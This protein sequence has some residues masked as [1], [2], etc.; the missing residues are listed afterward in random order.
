[1]TTNNHPAHGPVSLDR[2][3]QISE[4]LSKASA[5]SD[6][7]NLGYAM[8][9]AVK[10]IDGAIA[11]FGAEPV[12][13]RY[14]YVHTPKTE[15]HGSPFT[16]EWKLCDSEDE[17]NPSDCFERQPLYTAPPAPVSVPDAISTRQAIAKMESHEPCD[18][19]NVAYKFGWNACR[20]AMLQTGNSPV[21][22]DG[23]IPVSERMPNDKD[24]VW[25]WGYVSGWTESDGFEAYYDATRNKWWTI[26][27]ETVRKVTHWMPLPA[28]PLW[29]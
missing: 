4:I 23:W 9:D 27:D 20:S 29:E 25:C 10:V 22:P 19:I 13:W 2:L 14:R 15:E 3:H 7:G 21:T 17:C 16:T 8:A 1:M 24:F 12:A 18:S 6:G 5:Q 11:S 28:A 26:D